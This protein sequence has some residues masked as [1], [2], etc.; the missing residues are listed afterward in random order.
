M[1]AYREIGRPAHAHEVRSDAEYATKQAATIA[2]NATVHPS[3]TWQMPWEADQETTRQVVPFINHGRWVV[4]C[5][6][7]NASSYSPEW[8]VARCFECGAVYRVA[9]PEHSQAAEKILMRRPKMSNRNWVPYE[10]LDELRAE[11]LEHQLP[12]D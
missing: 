3:R 11:N 12:P 6:C 1:L 8:Q 10:T 5:L 7:M 2:H 9:P 4:M